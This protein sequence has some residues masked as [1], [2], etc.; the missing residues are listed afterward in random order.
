MMVYS[1]RVVVAVVAVEYSREERRTTG[2]EV[3]GGD[4]ETR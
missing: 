4:T 3:G 2:A 1:G